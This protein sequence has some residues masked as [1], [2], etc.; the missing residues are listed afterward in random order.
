MINYLSSKQ[1][2]KASDDIL[3]DLE[4]LRCNIHNAGEKDV[5]KIIEKQRL[6]QRNT[7]LTIHT[8]IEAKKAIEKEK[9]RL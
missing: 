6:L 5:E 8:V 2:E 9:G 3:N 1:L 7:I 4:K